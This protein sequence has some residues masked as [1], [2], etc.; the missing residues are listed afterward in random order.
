MKKFSNK[1]SSTFEQLHSFQ[2]EKKSFEECEIKEIIELFEEVDFEKIKEYFKDLYYIKGVGVFTT[3]EMFSHTMF[4]I[5]LKQEL[6]PTQ[7][8]YQFLKEQQGIQTLQITSSKWIQEW[9]YSKDIPIEF[10][11]KKSQLIHPNKYYL[12]EFEQ[13]IVGIGQVEENKKFLKNW[14]NISTYLF[15]G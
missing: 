11:V 1:H 4:L 14:Y 10:G 5:E 7:V 13:R 12:V 6:I 8:F 2:V 15:E 9:L 3:Q